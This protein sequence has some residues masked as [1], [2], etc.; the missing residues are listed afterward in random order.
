MLLLIMP[1]QPGL[2]LGT[3][4][5]L[6][7]LTAFVRQ[8]SPRTDVRVLDLGSTPLGSLPDAAR[9]CFADASAGPAIVGVTTTTA[10]YQAALAA[11][12]AFK[13]ARPECA[14]VFGGPHASADAETVLRGHADCVDF[15]IVG[16]GE[17]SL[18][19]FLKTYPKVDGVP[20]LAYIR[21]GKLVRNPPPPPLS[22]AEL[23]AIPLAIG[24]E[25]PGVPGKFGH[26]T[27]VSARGCPLQCAFCAVGGEAIRAKSVPRVV[28]DL[29]NLVRHG[30]SSI[31]IED[32]FFAHSPFR[33]R[34]LC[35]ALAALQRSGVSFGWDCQT[36]VESL[37]PPGVVDLLAHAGC[38]AVYV[39]VESLVPEHL[40]YLNKTNNPDRYLDQ[41]E[42]VV[43]PRLLASRVAC[44]LNLQLGLPGETE[45]HTARTLG[46]LSRLGAQATRLGKK[47]TIFPQLH[48]VYPGTRHFEEGVREGRFVRDIF[49]S[50]TEWEASQLPVLTWL[51]EHF[52]HGAGG[53]PEGILFPEDTRH[54]AFRVNPDAVLRVANTL[55]TMERIPG[56]QV[57]RYGRH[58]ASMAC[59]GVASNVQQ[60]GL[61]AA[62][63][64]PAGG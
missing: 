9:S 33:T 39:G 21:D 56:V 18:D 16:E 63:A 46:V 8:Q 14:V 36:R 41:L 30:Y 5:A 28:R 25:F 47:I 1:P 2:L 40:L 51:G 12:R 4:S 31:A 44:F 38:E 24:D 27:Y 42:H 23:D 32:N 60:E 62:G 53:L 64:L 15:V 50:F 22:V 19:A 49:E 55:T 29:E 61:A 34:A 20:G 43:V 59:S 10:T 45:E 17:R 35:H 7:A 48:V 52:A 3:S 11:A 54:A 6:G 37:A 57:F 13:K 26:V 58:I